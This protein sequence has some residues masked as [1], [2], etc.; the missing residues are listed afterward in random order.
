[1]QNNNKISLVIFDMDGTLFDT[2]QLG[3][4]CWEQAFKNLGYEY[5]EEV[6]VKKIGLSHSDSQKLFMDRYGQDFCYDDVKK[7]KRRVIRVHIDEKGTPVKEGVKE[8]IQFLDDQ[9][10][11]KVVA[12]SRRKEMTDYYIK[13]AGMEN[14]FDRV[15]TGEMIQRGKPAP[16][17]F[18]MAAEEMGE[19]PEN[20]L[21]VEDSKNGV[22][23][24]INANIRC[25]IVPDVEWNYDEV[26]GENVRFCRNMLEV[27]K[28]V[29]TQL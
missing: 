12:T 22:L 14:C 11:K 4:Q 18:L 19:K 8:M 3:I 24:S 16:D 2:E 6:M 10:I 25:C 26:T 23:A 29:E 13:Q 21:V 9:N 7:E 20:C 5:D 27:K 15:F 28:Y 17:I 1:M